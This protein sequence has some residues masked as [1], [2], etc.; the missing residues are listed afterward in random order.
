MASPTSLRDERAFASVTAEPLSLDELTRFVAD[1]GAG[2]ISTFT[3]VTRDNFGG[4][5]VLKLDYEAYEPMAVKEM[6]VRDGKGNKARP[7]RA[8]RGGE[9]ARGGRRERGG[10]RGGPRGRREAS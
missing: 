5:K 7:C 10:G 4:K 6:M 9:R 2:A 3:G 8:R 1:P